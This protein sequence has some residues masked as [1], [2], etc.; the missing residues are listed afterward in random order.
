MRRNEC[1]K[2]VLEIAEDFHQFAEPCLFQVWAETNYNIE[3]SDKAVRMALLRAHRQGLLSRSEGKFK[4][5]EKGV[6]RL[7][8]LRNSA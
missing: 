3:I 8:Y 6:Q 2:L 7:L 5:T 1:K 4:L